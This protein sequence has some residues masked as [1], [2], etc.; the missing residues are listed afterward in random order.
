[1]LLDDAAERVDG[2]LAWREQAALDARAVDG[3]DVRGRAVKRGQHLF[4]GG[5]DLL[6]GDL[7]RAPAIGSL[8]GRW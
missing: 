1:M 5:E 2:D 6:G 8:L 3:G 4:D 7:S